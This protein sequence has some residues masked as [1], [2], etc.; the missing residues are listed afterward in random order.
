MRVVFGRVWLG[1]ALGL[2]LAFA[3]GPLAWMALV[4]L[5]TPEEIARQ[6]F[7]PDA[8]KALAAGDWKGAGQ[9]GANYRFLL[10]LE[11]SFPRYYWNSLVVAAGTVVLGVFLDSLAG[12]AFAKLP[13]P[14]RRWIFWV[15]LATLMVPYPVLLVPSFYLFSRLGLYNTHLALII[16]GAV[17]AF[18]IFLVRQYMISIPDE[19]LHAARIDGA[20]DW[21]I[22]R[23][24]AWPLA[25][26][27][28]AALAVLRFLGSWNAYVWPLLL[29]NQEKMKTIPLGLAALQDSH[30]KIDVGVQMAGSLLATAPVLILFFFLQRHFIAGLT[31]GA[32]KE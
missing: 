10:G 8:L 12:F 14:G 21:Q 32:V 31:L 16:P 1:A 29:T 26:P 20:S 7:W 22:F 9:F 30:G 28:I 11:S 17:S 23:W 13:F 24:V 5:K 25:R 19:L 18:G 4:S 2:A 6:T 27:V 15:L 3:L